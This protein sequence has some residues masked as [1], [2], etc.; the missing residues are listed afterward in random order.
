MPD[1]VIGLPADVSCP[2]VPFTVTDVTEPVPAP[3]AC[4]EA[5]APSD[6]KIS[7]ALPA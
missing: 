4:Q 6:D 3:A 5:L 2:V 1:V 7:P